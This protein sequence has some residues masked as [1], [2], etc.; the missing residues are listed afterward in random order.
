MVSQPG[1]PKF[2]QSCCAGFPSSPSG[3]CPFCSGIGV[4][5]SFDPGWKLNSRSVGILSSWLTA[6]SLALLSSTLFAIRCATDADK[7]APRIC[8]LYTLLCL[9]YSPPHQLQA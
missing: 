5:S 8:C 7:G 2:E 9:H 3:P 6:S 4:P 1:G